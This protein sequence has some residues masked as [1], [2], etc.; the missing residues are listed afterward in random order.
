M[1]SDTR[2]AAREGL[3]CFPR[4]NLEDWYFDNV[5]SGVHP[6]VRCSLKPKSN[7]VLESGQSSLSCLPF[8]YGESVINLAL[9]HFF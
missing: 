6:G 7:P 2:T 8:R 3:R 1:F 5:V 9:A 4:D